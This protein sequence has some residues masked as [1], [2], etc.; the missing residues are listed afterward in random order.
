MTCCKFSIFA[1]INVDF[2]AFLSKVAS[3]KNMF[4][5]YPQSH[6]LHQKSQETV[7][8]C[9]NLDEGQVLNL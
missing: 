1:L 6:L 8:L 7:I 2:Q 9:R 4:S 5:L 3:E